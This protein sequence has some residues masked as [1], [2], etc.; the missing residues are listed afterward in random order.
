MICKNSFFSSI[1]F[2]KILL[3]SFT[4][5][6]LLSFHN[7]LRAQTKS[8]REHTYVYVSTYTRGPSASAVPGLNVF[9]FNPKDG[10]LIPIQQVSSTNPSWI[11]LDPS[12]RFLYVCYSLR[13]EKGLVFG[14]IEAYSI[15]P[16]TGMLQL[17]NHL[18]IKSGPAQL[19]VAPDGK[20]LVIANY[21]FGDYTLVSIESDGSIGTI[22]SQLKNTGKGPQRRQDSPHPHAVTF[23]PHK[24]FVGA[25]DLGIDK[26]ETFRLLGDSLERIS[27]RS[28]PAGMGPRHIAFSHNSKTLYVI[29]ELDG[30]II[31][32]A[33]DS[34]T[35]QIGNELQTVPTSPLGYSGPQSG[36]EIVV[37][38]TGKF[39]YAS[40]RGSRSIVGYRIDQH[41]GKLSTIN[42]VTEGIK[43]PTSFI[44]DPSGKWLYVPNNGDEDIIQF[45]IDPKTGVLK[46][47]GQKTLISAPN[48]ILFRKPE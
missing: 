17:L 5:M 10:S 45:S 26:V 44:I 6:A 22:K 42:F 25:A 29:G 7:K 21:F 13:D 41:N 12:R 16:Q 34:T 3:A 43:N 24:Q 8:A 39:L 15:N 33:Y 48:V 40:N 1:C 31:A 19:T 27:E 11:E 38:P 2:T 23:D 9:Q 30:K 32:F 14:S 18:P 36:A 46:S 28:V 4:G 47:T 35:G 37:H 20:H